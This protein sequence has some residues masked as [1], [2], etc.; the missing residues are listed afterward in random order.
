MV[1]SYFESSW[2][3]I[4]EDTKTNAKF[5]W[6]SFDM[7]LCTFF[8]RFPLTSFFY[9]LLKKWFYKYRILRYDVNFSHYSTN[10][11]MKQHILKTRWQTDKKTKT[12]SCPNFILLYIHI[13]GIY[14]NLVPLSRWR[15]RIDSSSQSLTEI[16]IPPSDCDGWCLAFE[17]GRPNL[18]KLLS[19]TWCSS[20]SSSPYAM[21][22]TNSS[23]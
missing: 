18:K 14:I 4:S 3:E 19:F 15:E 6:I 10:T 8:K 16:I 13:L 23:W 12:F 20:S 21:S 5:C 9:L 11:V 2:C 7:Y 1:I 22:G 17:N